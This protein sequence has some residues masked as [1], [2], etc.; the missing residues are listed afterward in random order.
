ML[1]GQILGVNDSLNEVEV[2]EDEVLI[3]THDEDAA[4]VELDV[5]ALLL[6]LE[7]IEE[8]TALSS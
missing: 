7:G 4:N 8:C 2:L 3:V 5:V 6:G 1:R